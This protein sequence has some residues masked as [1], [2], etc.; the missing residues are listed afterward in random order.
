MNSVRIRQAREADYPGVY[1]CLHNAFGEGTDPRTFE[2]YRGNFVPDRAFI[3]EEHG[4]VVGTTGAGSL[5]LTVPGGRLTAGGLHWAGVLPTHR[6]QG[7]FR[8]LMRAQLDEIAGRG[9]C[10]AVLHASEGGIYERFGFGPAT[11][12]HGFSLDVR[13]AELR[14]GPPGGRN[15]IRDSAGGET[16]ASANRGGMIRLAKRRAAESALPAVWERVRLRRAGQIGRPE[17]FWKEFLHELDE[18]REGQGLFFAFHVPG[19]D[20]PGAPETDDA[21]ATPADDGIN[22]AD[23]YAVYWIEQ[24]W[25]GHDPAHIVHLAELVDTDPSAR[26]ALWRYLLS[27]DLVATLKVENCPADESLWWM[28]T[29]PRVMRTTHLVDGLQIR[30]LDVPRALAARKYQ[31]DGELVFEVTDEFRPLSGGTYH[32]SVRRGKVE[33]RAAKTPASLRLNTTAL[34]RA[35]LGDQSF[36]AMSA[37]GLVAE[38]AS[39]ALALADALFRTP[40]APWSATVF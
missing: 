6:R 35:Y 30:L 18:E 4:R 38:S 33:C 5:E 15:A 23:G 8:R 20:S 9:E 1:E 21:G 36:T 12:I 10:L 14:S 39:G 24:N 16:E 25:T 7:I 22:A 17:W 28:L 26:A 32:L 11:R 29:N 37:A 34:A 40:L 13:R 3:A 31:C 19:Q 2:I 27:L